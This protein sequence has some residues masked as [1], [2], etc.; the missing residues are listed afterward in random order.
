[1]SECGKF[2]ADGLTWLGTPG[3]WG[4]GIEEEGEEDIEGPTPAL[5]WALTRAKYRTPSLRP[6]T[7]CEPVYTP[8]HPQMSG[9]RHTN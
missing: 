4:M 3:T 7:V 1:M 5:F 2:R 8:P 9:L 6:V